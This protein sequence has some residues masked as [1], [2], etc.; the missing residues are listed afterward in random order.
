[1][2]FPTSPP[3]LWR[4]AEHYFQKNDFRRAA[5]L[6]EQLI[7]Y[8]ATGSYDRSTGFDPSII[9]E[10]AVLNLGACYGRLGQF[11]RAEQMFRLLLPV[12]AYQEQATK[13]LAE[14]ERMRQQA[15]GG[16]QPS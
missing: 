12:P 16:A 4:A 13:G 2:W 9:Q 5:G 11:S 1:R 8:G 10:S 14:V 3:L 15:A 6:L 7:H